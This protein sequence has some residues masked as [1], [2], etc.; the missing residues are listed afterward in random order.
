MD[1]AEPDAIFQAQAQRSL[2]LMLVAAALLLCPFF[3][4]IVSGYL[5]AALIAQHARGVGG[6]G[7]DALRLHHAE[8]AGDVVGVALA[9]QRM[10]GVLRALHQ[11]GLVGPGLAERSLIALG[12][13]KNGP[14]A[15]LVAD[16]RLA[17]RLT[18]AALRR[19]CL[20]A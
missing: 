20:A 8:V 4:R 15:V 10:T 7:G 14:A 3:L 5:I 6:G 11:H 13:S 17:G 2:L 12:R 19:D 16:L 1:D 9:Q 18:L